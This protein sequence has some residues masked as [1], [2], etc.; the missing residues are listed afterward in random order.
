MISIVIAVHYQVIV[1][2]SLYGKSFSRKMP[3]KTTSSITLVQKGDPN[4]LK[5]NP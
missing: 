3:Q 1:F 4:N 5:D 2:G